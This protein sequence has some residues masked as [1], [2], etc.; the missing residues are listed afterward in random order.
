MSMVDLHKPH[1]T[2]HSAHVPLECDATDNEGR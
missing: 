2:V 1:A